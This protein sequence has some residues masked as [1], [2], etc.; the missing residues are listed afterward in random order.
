MVTQ[1][2]DD[3]N[4]F[5]FYHQTNL[6]GFYRKVDIECGSRL[7][8][9]KGFHFSKELIAQAGFAF[10]GRDKLRAQPVK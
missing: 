4:A 9:S 3:L 1:A 6:W 7:S 2:N 5:P 8:E 10:F